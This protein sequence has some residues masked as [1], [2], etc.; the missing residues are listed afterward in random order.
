MRIAQL[1][2][3]VKTNKASFLLFLTPVLGF[4]FLT[5]FR[6]KKFVLCDVPV[7]RLSSAGAKTSWNAQK[8]SL[9]NGVSAGG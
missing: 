6:G 1:F 5:L 9:Q 8:Y 4:L 7:E 2:G 3:D